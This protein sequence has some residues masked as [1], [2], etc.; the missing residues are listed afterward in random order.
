MFLKFNWFW[1]FWAVMM[2]VA[3][4]VPANELPT[5]YWDLFR[6]DFLA[7]VALF[8]V[9]AF[10]MANGFNKQTQYFRLRS[11]SIKIVLGFCVVYGVAL[12]GL[13]FFAFPSRNFELQDLVAD[14][15]GTLMGLGL[16]IAL[17]GKLLRLNR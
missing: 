11:Q 5:P 16:L 2:L 6:F 17:Y 7:H 15:L 14:L 9:L 12:E 10:S 3:H 13:Q 8:L 4:A 1:L